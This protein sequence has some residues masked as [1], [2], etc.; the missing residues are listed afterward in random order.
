[1]CDEFLRLGDGPYVYLT[2]F[3]KDGTPVGIP[4]WVVRDGAHLAVWVENA[5]TWKVERMRRNPR[6]TVAACDLRGNRRGPEIPATA[7]VL[8]TAGTDRVR[9]LIASKY[10]LRGRFALY[11]NRIARG[12]NTSVGIALRPEQE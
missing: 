9:S 3:R 11:A 12:K 5:D 7:E 6:V 10:R 2:H 8:D 4:I 1:M